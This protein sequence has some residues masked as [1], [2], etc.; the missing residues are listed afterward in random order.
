MLRDHAK[1]NGYM[2]ARESVDE[3]RSSRIADR[4]QFRKT[5]DEDSKPVYPFPGN[6]VSQSAEPTLEDRSV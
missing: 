4:P 2:V 1:R 3:S 6:V 5:I